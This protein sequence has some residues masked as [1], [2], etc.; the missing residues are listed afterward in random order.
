MNLQPFYEFMLVV[1]WIMVAL[2]GMMGVI[3]LVSIYQ[4]HL[5]KRRSGSARA[6]R[7]IGP[8]DR[9]AHARTR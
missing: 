3:G 7:R 2:A 4:D 8:A 5:T 9:R 6:E 1:G